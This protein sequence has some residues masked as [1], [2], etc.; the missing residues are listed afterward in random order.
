MEYRSSQVSIALMATGGCAASITAMYAANALWSS[1]SFHSRCKA[2]F[3]PST[4][5]ID[6]QAE[7]KWFCGLGDRPISLL[8]SHLK[9]ILAVYSKG[10][11]QDEL[12]HLKNRQWDTYPCRRGKGETGTSYG[13]PTFRKGAGDNTML[14]KFVLFLSSIIICP[15]YKVTLSDQ[16]QVTQEMRVSFSDLVLKNLACPALPGGG[17]GRTHSRRSCT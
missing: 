2:V 6:E 12:W 3:T 5:Q 8:W 14:H 10:N 16:D 9:G 15:L 17:K 13:G 4:T 11:M 7:T 1:C